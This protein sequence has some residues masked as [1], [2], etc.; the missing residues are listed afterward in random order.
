ML[1]GFY[2]FLSYP[3]DINTFKKGLKFCNHITEN[4]CFLK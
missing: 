2:N 4:I 3:F 1:I